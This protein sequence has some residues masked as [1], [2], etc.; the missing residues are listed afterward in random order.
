VVRLHLVDRRTYIGIPWLIVGMAFVVTV[1]IA[2][3]IGFTTGGAKPMPGMPANFS[4]AASNCRSYARWP[5]ATGGLFRKSDRA[6][7]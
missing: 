1:F 6:G 5:G 4:A 7:S 2:Q 3:I